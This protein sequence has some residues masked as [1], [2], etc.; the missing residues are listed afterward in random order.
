VILLDTH[1]A[2]WFTAAEDALGKQSEILARQA[3]AEDR[4]AISAI[5]FWEIAMLTAKGRL[6]GDESP[7]EQRT[8]ILSG[9]I[10]EL[11]VTGVIAVISV[12]LKDLPGDPADRFIAATAV[13]HNATLMTADKRLLEWQHKLQRQNASK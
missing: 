7:L 8:R 10:I 4:L 2:I 11:P 3:L 1:V 13:V 6:E 5:S 9:G 12:E